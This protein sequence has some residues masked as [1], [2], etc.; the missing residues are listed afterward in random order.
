M[1]HK[2]EV[3]LTKINDMLSGLPTTGGSVRRARVHSWEDSSL[4]GISLYMGNDIPGERT[5]IRV[6]DWNLTIII[7]SVC[8]RFNY[9]AIDTTLNQIRAEVT[10]VM[11]ATPNLDLEFVIDVDELGAEEPE[12]SA[13]GETTSSAKVYI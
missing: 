13:E 12:L 7:H 6:S 2:A 9:A 10:E 4:P 3:I 8:K 1:D 5:N 11:L